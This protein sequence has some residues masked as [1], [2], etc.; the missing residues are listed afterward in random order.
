MAKFEINSEELTEDQYNS[1]C[2]QY[3]KFIEE[4][5]SAAA[6]AANKFSN[7]LLAEKVQPK[8]GFRKSFL[9]GVDWQKSLL[10]QDEYNKIVYILL[11]SFSTAEYDDET[12][13]GAMQ[14]VGKLCK[15]FDVDATA[16][17]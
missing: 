3:K 1:L 7:K 13:K 11:A 5:S 14:F 16:L 17:L 6:I 12:K 15:I 9:A 8:E 4:N 10:T 2:N